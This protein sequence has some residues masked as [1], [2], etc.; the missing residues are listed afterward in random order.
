MR[1][2][3]EPVAVRIHALGHAP[4]GRR[5]RKESGRL[6]DDALLVGADE[7]RQSR[8]DALGPFRLFAQDEDG[9]SEG[10]GLLLDSAGVRQHDAALAQPPDEARVVERLEQFDVGQSFVRPHRREHVG[11][12]VHDVEEPRLREG[13]R[14]ARDRAHDAREGLAETLAP[15][16]GDEHRVGLRLVPLLPRDLEQGID[17]RVAGPVDPR[18][19]HAFG[20]ERTRRKDRRDEVRVGDQIHDAAV[21]LLGKGVLEVA[22]AQARLDVPDAHAAVE[23]GD[24][25]AHRR[26][27]VAL[28]EEPV[29]GEPREE[30]IEGGED[31]GGDLVGGLP[32]AHEVEVHVRLE[33]EDVE[34]LV[35]HFPM[36]GRRAQDGLEALGLPPEPPHD[37]RELD[38]FGPRSDDE[39][40]AQRSRRG[41]SHPGSLRS[42]A[43]SSTSLQRLSVSRASAAA[44][45]PRPKK[46]DPSPERAGIAAAPPGPSVGVGRGSRRGR[47][48]RG[49]D[50]DHAVHHRSPREAVHDAVVRVVARSLERVRERG[51]G[52]Q[53]SRVPDLRARGA[54]RSSSSGGPPARSRSPSRPAPR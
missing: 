51:A 16:G 8:G 54:R 48:G 22:R 26:R 41:E 23:G 36:L 1:S 21:H 17:D 9:L 50:V 53:D 15:V 49:R 24:G 33:V 19:R 2:R 39:Q 46:R 47:G 18:L 30:G 3:G 12:G 27:R 38:G 40:D 7:L 20:R 45:R 42:R 5:V 13:P 4:P 34:H 6:G 35:E 43:G 10:R 25:R 37:R 11:V 52:G 28:H 32:G 31:P 29:R 44:A 14:Q